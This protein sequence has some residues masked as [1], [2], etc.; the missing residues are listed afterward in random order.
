M[1]AFRGAE[2]EHTNVERDLPERDK[3]IYHQFTS[4]YK[5]TRDSLY[6]VDEVGYAAK[7]R[8]RGARA[9]KCSCVTRKACACKECRDKRERYKSPLENGNKI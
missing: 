2:R 7:V 5:S 4:E 1:T 8:A 6:R 3:T 9:Y